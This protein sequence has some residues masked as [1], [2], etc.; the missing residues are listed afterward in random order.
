MPTIQ[1]SAMLSMLPSSPP[2]GIR[3]ETADAL[4]P[5][6]NTNGIWSSAPTSV[7]AISEIVPLTPEE[8]LAATGIPGPYPTNLFDYPGA[9]AQQLPTGDNTAKTTASVYFAGG[10]FDGM[11]FKDFVLGGFDMTFLWYVLQVPQALA[12]TY[13]PQLKMVV[14]SPSTGKFSTFVFEVG[15]GREGGKKGER[16]QQ[17]GLLR[18]V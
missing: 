17:A 11:L 12:T 4:L 2:T 1:P 8:V 9:L 14:A 15:E 3:D 6:T 5:T 13:T 10:A 16:A 7:D 18:L